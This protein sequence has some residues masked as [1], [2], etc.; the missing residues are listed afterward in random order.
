MREA[1]EA[2][3]ASER[4]YRSI[5]DYSVLGVFQSTPE[6]RFITVNPAFAQMT[7]FA[8][9]EEMME[10]VTDIPNQLY[11]SPGDRE[12]FKSA[13]GNHGLVRQFE[14]LF[15]RKD[16]SLFWVLMNVRAIRGDDGR[17]LY[18]EGSAEDVTDRKRAKDALKESEERY[19]TAIESSN[20]G[21]AIDQAQPLRKGYLL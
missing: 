21:V 15:R 11:A 12:E 14:T 19:R 7:G 20:D 1:E 9:P 16:G 3:R 17:V 13:F 10:F 18:Y 8:S 6:G 2:L 4:K 5:F